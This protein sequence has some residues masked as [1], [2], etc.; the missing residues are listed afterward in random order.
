MKTIVAGKT[1]I[2]NLLGKQAPKD[3]IYRLMKYV[4]QLETDEGIL[5]HNVI[6]GQLVL[7]D[8]QETR[9]LQELPCAY[10]SE[11]MNQLI[12]NY[13]LVP[14]LEDEKQTVLK[15]RC[16]LKRLKRSTKINHYEVFTTTKCNA[17]CYYCFES[18]YRRID[19]DEQTMLQTVDFM[20][21]HKDNTPLQIRWFGG[22]PLLGVKSI[23]EI[24]YELKKRGVEYI[25]AITTNGYIFHQDMVSKAKQLWNLKEAQ[26]TLDGTEEVYNQVK[27][28]IGASESPFQRVTKNI[29]LLLIQGIK[30]IIRLNLDQDNYGN[31]IQ[32]CKELKERFGKYENAKIV[33]HVVFR[34]QGYKPIDRDDQAE[35]E[36]YR[37]YVDLSRLVES[38][39]MA[40]HKAQ[41]PSLRANSCMLDND[42]SVCL[43]ADGTLSKCTF[44]TDGN[45]IGHVSQPGLQT[46]KRKALETTAEKEECSDCPLYPRCI[47]L[48]KCPFLESHNERACQYDI[49]KTV[50]DMRIFYKHCQK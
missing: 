49:E 24:C 2:V 44:I 13:F 39:G 40:Q 19:M 37:Q 22:E 33:V 32:L 34:D 38:L 17:R 11:T 29:E 50:N 45:T 36:L 6:T 35:A 21:S 1:E 47:L 25:S 8:V 20:V 9:M 5:L 28:Y 4:L 27:A 26:I 43:Y 42:N 23:D 31:L 46:E 12:E 14:T 41:L 16:I 15:V 10:C 30:V 48:E 3:S 18:N 7:A